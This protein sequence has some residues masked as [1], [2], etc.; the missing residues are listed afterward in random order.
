MIVGWMCL[1]KV[2]DVIEDVYWGEYQRQGRLDIA[3]KAMTFRLAT[4]MLVYALLL[5]LTK[6][7][8]SALIAAT[9]YSFAALLLLLKWTASFFQLESEYTKEHI[10]RILKNCFPL[11]AGGFLS[12]YI[13]NAPKYAIDAT[14]TDELQACYG[15]IAMPVFVIGLLNG[16]IFNPM[17]CKISLLWEEKKMNLFI[18]QI[19]LQMMF[20][21]IIMLACLAGA[22]LLGVSVLSFLYHTDLSPYKS[23]LLILLLG[24]GFLGM[25]GLLN[26]IITIMRRQHELF[27]GY[28]LIAVLAFLLSKIVV[29]KYAMMGA[30]LLYTALMAGLCV[31]FLLVLLRGL[32]KDGYAKLK[33]F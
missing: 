16:F 31:C 4:S 32:R 8:L 26:A 25:S 28:L 23:E 27:I 21:I 19:L 22:W 15:F 3:S 24:G 33:N 11:F 30:A 20:V 9:A 10:C 1:F 2:P 5:V 17:L 6:N 18:K 12:F 7:Q 14:L 29:G 13:G